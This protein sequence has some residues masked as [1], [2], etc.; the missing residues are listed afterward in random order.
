MNQTAKGAALCSL[1]GILLT[2]VGCG[3][4]KH[5]DPKVYYESSAA[6]ARMAAELH[7][8]D[9]GA[10]VYQN[11]CCGSMEPL[12]F[13]GDWIVAKAETYNDELLGKAVSYRRA[14]GQLI[15]HRLVSGNAKNGFIASGDNNK[16]SEPDERV[17]R[18]NYLETCVAI[19]KVA[20]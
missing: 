19:Y 10:S 4:A 9:I 15:L 16:R 13:A 11:Q 6:A 18:N 12:I 14:N 7:A 8:R 5:K 1:L 17:D 3:Y 2:L 20:K